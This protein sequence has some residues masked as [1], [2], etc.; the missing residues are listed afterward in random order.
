MGLYYSMH[1]ID[2]V[3][4]L[5]SG[6]AKDGEAEV[7]PPVRP[8]GGQ[9]MAAGAEQKFQKGFERAAG[10]ACQASRRQQLGRQGGRPGIRPRQCDVSK[11]I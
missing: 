2:A 10:D 5:G 4:V 3:T 11:G 6:A 1:S 7:C 9:G 8:G